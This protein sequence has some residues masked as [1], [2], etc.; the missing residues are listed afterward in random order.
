MSTT[1]LSI[2]GKTYIEAKSPDADFSGVTNPHTS[3]DFY[4]GQ[5]SAATLYIPAAILRFTRS[6]VLQYKKITKVVLN[7]A[8][9]ANTWNQFQ[10]AIAPYKSDAALS[11]INYNNYTSKGTLG[12]WLAGIEANA[13]QTGTITK[14]IDITS[15]FSSNLVNDVFNIMVAVNKY[16]YANASAQT[17]GG[18]SIISAST[19]LTVTYESVAQLAPTPSYPKDISIMESESTLLSWIWNS[20]TEAVQSGVILEYKKTTDNNWTVLTLT[21]TE[22]SY[23]LNAALAPG[24]YEWRIKGINDISETSAYSETATFTVIGKPAAPIIATP[25]NK[26]L[27]EISWTASGQ[28][29]AE[30]RLFDEDGNE[31][32]HETHATMSTSWKPNFFLKGTY[33]FSIRIKNASDLW[34]DWATTSFTIDAAGPTAATLAVNPS[35]DVI[36]LTFAIPDAVE[37]A[38]VRVD[39]NG[40][41]IL[42]AGLT[43][44]DTE[45]EDDTVSS[46]K[47]YAYL[48]RTYVNGYKDSARRSVSINFPGYILNSENNGKLMLTMSEEQ[49]MPHSET[50]QKEAALLTLSGRELPLTEYGEHASIQIDKKAHCTPE[51]KRILDKI[52]RSGDKVFYRDGRGNAFPVSVTAATYNEYMKEDY[53]VNLSLTR[54]EESEVVVNV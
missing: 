4:K 42:A 35:N 30:L 1:T 43:I 15:M 8:V 53:F 21:Q 28:Y 36:K 5:Y 18:A 47:E 16:P 29:A 23:R 50:I 54:T 44:L 20:D 52:I 31:I 12:D 6:S 13:T 3:Y 27:T 49:F 48:I 11:G 14:S 7:L 41:K 25:A 37:A 10:Y 45:F 32:Y 33:S 19:S 2:T 39:G 38:L 40:E 34:S 22:H 9:N 26:A 17:V 24:T 46:G 51:Q